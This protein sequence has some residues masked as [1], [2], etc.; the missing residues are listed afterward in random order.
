MPVV[1]KGEAMRAFLCVS[2]M[3]GVLIAAGAQSSSELS[4]YVRNKDKSPVKGVVVTI[5]SFGVATDSNGY[6]KLSYLKPGTKW[7]LIS[8]PGKI[9][10]SFKVIVGSTP[11]QQD[12]VID[13]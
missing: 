4:G 3:L 2:L 6:Y 13:W 8:P 1:L 11:T 9:T 5:G 7:V 10:R 12:F